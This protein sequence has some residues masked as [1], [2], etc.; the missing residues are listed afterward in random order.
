MLSEWI[1]FGSIVQA[2]PIESWER[3][4]GFSSVEG[5]KALGLGRHARHVHGDRRQKVQPVSL[6]CT[7]YLFVLNPE[8]P[9]SLPSSV[10][11]RLAVLYVFRPFIHQPVRQFLR[12]FSAYEAPI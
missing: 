7:D 9:R 1:V 3:D 5:S 8:N 6:F 12:S 11:Y 2:V 10:F 4:W